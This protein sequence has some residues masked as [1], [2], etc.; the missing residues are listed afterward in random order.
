MQHHAS[1]RDDARHTAVFAVRLVAATATVVSLHLL[2]STACAQQPWPTL[3]IRGGAL[4]ADL[5]SDVRIDATIGTFGTSIDLENTLGFN[6]RSKTF[7]VDG[8][9]RMSRRNQLQIDY[10]RIDRDVSRSL[11]SE[12]ILFHDTI[13]DRNASV[14]VF[15]DS[16]YLSAYYG[17]AF[18]ATSSVELGASIGITLV[19]LHAGIGLSGATSAADVSRDLSEDTRFDVPVPLPGF[20]V[21]IRPHPRV[22]IIGSARLLEVTIDNITAS[23]REAKGGVEVKLAGPLGVGG[24]YYYNHISAERDESN[25]NG[26]IVYS[27]NGPQ[28]YGVLAF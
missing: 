15:F 7:F 22:T 1:C 8:I 21:N 2:A 6:T 14:D 27:F 26:R 25:T 9:W 11:L 16:S 3:V 19:R 20:F 18:V 17:F 13:F 23:M 12:P 10:E 28:V 24:A 5:S 4:I